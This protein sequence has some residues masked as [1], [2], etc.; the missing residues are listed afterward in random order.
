VTLEEAVKVAE[1]M[2]G[3]GL[4][5]V[6][7]RPL[8]CQL[9]SHNTCSLIYASWLFGDGITRRRW[10]LG[11]RREGGGGDE[12]G[13]APSCAALRGAGAAQDGAPS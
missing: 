1:G 2:G 12:G 13:G 11:R 4:Q 10:R 5:C 8:R 9:N 6:P 7:N 3:G